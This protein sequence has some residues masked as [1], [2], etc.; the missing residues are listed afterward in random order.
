MPTL[1]PATRRA[2]TIASPKPPGPPAG[3]RWPRGAPASIWLVALLVVACVRPLAV[4]ERQITL[5]V[6]LPLTTTSR[7]QVVLF[8]A[9]GGRLGDGSTLVRPLPAVE[10]EFAALLDAL[11]DAATLRFDE[12]EGRIRQLIPATE[13]KRP[14]IDATEEYPDEVGRVGYLLRNFWFVFYAQKE[15]E[16]GPLPAR[17]W[18]L[19]RL[20]VFRDRPPT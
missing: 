15:S 18:R 8:I 13:Q 3:A 2:K 12:I 17:E 16:A 19:T 7:E 20:A 5:R 14:V 4:P 1:P 9:A 11:R 6:A 10:A